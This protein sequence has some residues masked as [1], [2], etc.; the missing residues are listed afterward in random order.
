MDVQ[1]YLQR[2]GFEG[3]VDISLECLTNLQHAHQSSV[4]Y[5]NLDMFTNVRKTLD[6]QI[7][8]EKIVINERGGWCSE[9]NG[10]FAWLLS[11]IGFKVQVGAAIKDPHK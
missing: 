6:Y 8:Y 2:I 3:E 5:E 4:P 11:R 7:L 9:L 10:M 1:K